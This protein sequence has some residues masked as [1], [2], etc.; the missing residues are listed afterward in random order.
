MGRS[1]SASTQS[2]SPAGS[3]ETDPSTNPRRATRDGGSC[4]SC[5]EMALGKIA[6]AR[7]KQRTADKATPQLS[8]IRNSQI[9]IR[10]TLGGSLPSHHVMLGGNQTKR[11]G[12][13][14][15]PFVE[16]GRL[17]VERVCICGNACFATPFGFS[18]GGGTR[19]PVS[20]SSL[21]ILQN[22]V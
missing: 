13:G 10:K 15:L 8:F 4:W 14:N 11:L 12:V 18:V 5:A 16:S 19:H 20:G 3:N 17:R 22:C 7:S 6:T 1:G 9:R 21:K 2:C